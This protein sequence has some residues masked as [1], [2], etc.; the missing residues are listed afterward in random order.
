MMDINADLLRKFIIF[1]Y[2]KLALLADKPAS[3]VAV[4][5]ENMSNQELTE[6]LR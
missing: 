3:G 5:N 6:E 4:Q 2:K 1:F